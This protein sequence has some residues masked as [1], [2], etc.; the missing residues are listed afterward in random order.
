MENLI[1]SSV[2]TTLSDWDIVTS[3]LDT[4]FQ[5]SIVGLSDYKTILRGDNGDLLNVCKNTYTPQTNAQFIDA[6]E[7]FASVTNFPVEAIYEVDGG[8]KMLGYLRCTETFE[9]GGFEF[10]DY[11]MLGN[12][13]DGST[14][15]FVGNS[16]IMV[17]C[18]NRFAQQFRMLKVRHCSSLHNGVNQILSGFE[19][20]KREL[21][22]Y[23][24]TLDEF[25][26]VEVSEE[27][28]QSLIARLANLSNE[29]IL[30]DKEISTKKRNIMTSIDESLSCEMEDIGFNLYGL[31]GG[32]THYT[33]HVLKGADES[34]MFG[35][36]KILNLEGYNYCKSVARQALSC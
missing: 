20:Y 35:R 28:K 3:T 9:V 11:L 2:L 34:G 7:R 30:G 33:T 18:N 32:V 5:D 36:A 13:H 29:E 31:F 23:Y 8:K 14:G 4:K 15:F 10:K 22:G 1:S 24:K 26:K 6:V 12:S 27:I 17:R 21:S 16:N 19:S 25:S